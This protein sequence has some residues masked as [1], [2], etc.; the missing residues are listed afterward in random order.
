M[1]RSL[2]RKPAGCITIILLLTRA[3][4]ALA[5]VTDYRVTDLGT[6][7]GT[8]S[9]AFGLNNLGQVVGTSGTTHNGTQYAFLYTGGHMV[10]LGALGGTY[11]IATAINDHGEVVGLAGVSGSPYSA[12]LYSSGHMTALSFG[13]SSEAFGINNSDAIVGVQEH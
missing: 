8:F 11:G 1:T 10:S 6:L 9:G 13:P 2:F 3:T 5:D 7:G 4:I 12:F